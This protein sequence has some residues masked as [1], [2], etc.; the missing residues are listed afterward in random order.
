MKFLKVVNA[1]KKA[2]DLPLIFQKTLIFQLSKQKKRPQ[3][4]LVLK[5]TKSKVTL[6]KSPL[7]LEAEE[8]WIAVTNLEII[9]SVF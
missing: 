9:L 1:S 3:E 5:L 6:K 2:V 8:I 4:T 7:E